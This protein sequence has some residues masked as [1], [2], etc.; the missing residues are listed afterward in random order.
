VAHACNPNYLGG[1]RFKAN[2]I[3]EKKKKNYHKNAQQN[4][5][6]VSL[7]SKP[8]VLISNSCANKTKQKN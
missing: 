5:S 1:L 3:L 6:S 2:L 4:S 7:P 8:E